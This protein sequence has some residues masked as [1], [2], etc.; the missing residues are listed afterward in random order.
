LD[1][2]AV[3]AHP[4]D[5]EI[6]CGG[7]L[8]RLAQQ[9][10]RVGIVDLTDGEPTPAS[11]GPEVR[12]AEARRAAET[13][14]VAVRI[15]LDLPNRRLFDG[16]EARVALATAL[17]RHQPRLV[18]GPGAA[19]PLASPD[20]YQAMLI[21]EA[22]IFYTRLTK[23][24][25]YFEELP[26]CAA[27]TLLYYF[28]GPRLFAPPQPSCFVLDI[29]ATL[30]TKLAAIACYQTQFGHRPQILDRIRTIAQQQGTTAGFAAGEL[31]A[32][33]TAIGLRDLMT[34]VPP[35]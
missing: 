10:Y 18:L 1:V 7:T 6:S 30:E 2:V 33:P 35:R 11:P 5:V 29:S 31:L 22:A 28:L 26:P 13:L 12:L 14:G 4:D 32:S 9:G 15:T 24:E 16:F 25:Q 19:T 20:H 34:L 17:R 8:A 27:P 21:V 23:W 3:G